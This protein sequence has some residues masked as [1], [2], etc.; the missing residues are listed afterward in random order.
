ME[1]KACT[2]CG[3]EKKAANEYFAIK[4]TSK[5]GFKSS[6]KSCDSLY[7]KANK[8]RF[9]EKANEHYKNNKEYILEH[10][11]N[12]N[13]N[14]KLAKLKYNTTYYEENKKRLLDDKKM[15][16][17]ENKNTIKER[18]GLYYKHNKEIIIKKAKTYYQN[19]K[20]HKVQYNLDYYAKNKEGIC[21]KSKLYYQE[22]REFKKEYSKKYN[23]INKEKVKEKNRKW[24]TENRGKYNIIQQRREARKRL[25][26]STL[27]F[28][29]W[30]KIKKDFN[31]KCAYCGKEKKLE[32][33]HFLP[34]SK[35]GEYTHN[36]II[37]A[38][39]NCNCSKR[40]NL[41]NEWYPK[42]KYYN[43]KRERRILQYLSYNGIV[44][45]LSIF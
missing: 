33:E 41:F 45:Q 38:C 27:T 10:K 3:E 17:Q 23:E 15:Y 2:K 26:E 31:N 20:D 35:G 42:Y 32:Q 18:D 30:E 25:L 29:Q 4:N 1:R 19:N 22:N 44:Q 12:Y 28:K 6:C 36:N 7:Y 5:D 24:R 11:K 14:N 13:E 16:Y 40:D 8:K 34:I 21:Q 37:P 9:L 43:Q 39:R